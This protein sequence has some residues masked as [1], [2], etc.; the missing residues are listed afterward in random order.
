MGYGD[1]KLVDCIAND[2]LNDAF[3][4]ISMGLC[5]EKTANDFKITRQ[6]Q[7]DYCKSTY[8]RAIAASKNGIFKQEIASVIIKSKTGEE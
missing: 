1:K 4:K 3:N 2:G 8:Q 5:A 7:D 6:N